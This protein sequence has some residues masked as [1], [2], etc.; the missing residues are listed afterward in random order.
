MADGLYDRDFVLWSEAEAEKLRR[1][2]AGERVNDVDWENLIEEVKSLGRSEIRATHGL[3]YQAVSHLLKV[4]AWPEARHQGHWLR[5]AHVFLRDGRRAYAPSMAQRL[6]LDEMFEDARRRV[7][8]EGY[9][10]TPPIPLPETPWFTLA[11]LLAEDA[12]PEDILA[13]APRG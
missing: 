4:V 1:L 9:D 13:R 6:R 10:G 7:L 5:E 11:D 8:H 2:R 3:L 12:E